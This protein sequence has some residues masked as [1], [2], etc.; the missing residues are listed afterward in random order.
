M[1]MLFKSLKL[2][3]NQ[4]EIRTKTVLESMLM[5]VRPFAY[6][7]EASWGRKTVFFPNQRLRHMG[8]IFVCNTSNQAVRI[9]SSVKSC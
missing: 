7:E 3:E 4:I 1:V 2:H 9:I 8:N 6:W 5:M